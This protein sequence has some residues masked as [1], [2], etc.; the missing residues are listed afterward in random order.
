M[1]NSRPTLNDVTKSEMDVILQRL[2]SLDAELSQFI[3]SRLIMVMENGSGSP[4]INLATVPCKLMTH[5]E[6][7]Q[8]DL[9]VLEGMGRAIHTNFAAKFKI[10]TSFSKL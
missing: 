7:E 2:Q 5:L 9:I 1:V 8:C 10:G 4:C 3:Q 6:T